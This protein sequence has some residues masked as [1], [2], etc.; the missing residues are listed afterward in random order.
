MWT[1]GGPDKEHASNPASWPNALSH[2]YDS[3]VS[4]SKMLE[5]SLSRTNHVGGRAR[6]PRQG[7]VHGRGPDHDQSTESTT[8]RP[9][10]LPV[11]AAQ[12]IGQREIQRNE[13][14]AEST[15]AILPLLIFFVLVNKYLVW[16][17]IAGAVKS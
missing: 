7:G 4:C 17:M 2:V 10:T 12:L 15:A 13:L 9:K 5:A 1:Q 8:C 14:C 6:P 3:V 16:G 11:A